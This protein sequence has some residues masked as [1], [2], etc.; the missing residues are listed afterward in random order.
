MRKI[1]NR[2]DIIVV[3]FDPALGQ[4]QQGRRPALVIT[5]H[6]V[7]K[8]SNIVMI[9]AITNGGN[10]ARNMGFTVN[11]TGL[12]LETTGVVRCDQV[13][14]IDVVQRN[15]SFKEHAP[16]ELCS[17]VLGKLAAMLGI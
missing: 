2:G 3:D 4:E 1:F 16:D 9:A 17:E 6:E 14:S 15:A 13:R 11:L 7:N 5:P 8:L 10:F 12:G